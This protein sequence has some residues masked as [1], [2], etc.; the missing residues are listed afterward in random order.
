MKNETKS[1]LIC[2][3]GGQGTVLASRLLAQSAMKNGLFCRTAETIGMAQRGG[4]VT[5][6]VRMGE[7]ISSPLIPKGGADIIIGFEPGEALRHLPYLKPGGVMITAPD[8]ITPVAVGSA[9]Y[10]GKKALEYLKTAVKKLI[11]VDGEQVAK[12]CGSAR[13]LNVALI[14]AAI[15]SGL[16]PITK[17]DMT[18]VLCERLRPQFHEMNMLALEYGVNAGGKL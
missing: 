12:V 3:V 14:G 8:E 11:V 7:Q 13:A 16:L 5:S 18:Q 9:P 6:H 4:C 15:S 2:G 10:D 1:C 17:G